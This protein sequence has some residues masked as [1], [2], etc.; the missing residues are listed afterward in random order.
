MNFLA[1][2]FAY[3]AEE[4]ITFWLLVAFFEIFELRDIY[5]PNLIGLYKHT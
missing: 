2:V 3:H 4:Y 5:L 1:G